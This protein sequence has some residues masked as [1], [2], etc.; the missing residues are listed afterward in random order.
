[1]LLRNAACSFC[2][3]QTRTVSIYAHAINMPY[4]RD[5]HAS[6][7]N[8]D[9]VPQTSCGTYYS[10]D[11]TTVVEATALLL[12]WVKIATRLYKTYFNL[13]ML[14][15]KPAGSG[16]GALSQDLTK[17]TFLPDEVGIIIYS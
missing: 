4:F 5:T 15:S 3:C 16:G 17:M 7:K 12:H 8:L 13:N 9:G 14:I 10:L 11:L 1:M 2:F 6:N